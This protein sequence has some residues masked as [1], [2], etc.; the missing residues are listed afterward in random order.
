MI[1]RSFPLLES[2]KA[3]DLLAAGKMEG[4]IVLEA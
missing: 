2:R 4:K 3:L 1:T